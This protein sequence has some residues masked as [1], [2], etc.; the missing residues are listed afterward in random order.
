MKDRSKAPVF[1]YG[2]K[3]LNA[4]LENEYEK[5]SHIMVAKTNNRDII[6]IDWR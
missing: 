5:K 1:L 4:N 6:K 3:R 2:W